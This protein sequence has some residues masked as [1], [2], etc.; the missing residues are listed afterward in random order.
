MLVSIKINNIALIS[1]SKIEMK[2]GFNVLTGETGAGK[3]IIID[4]LNFVLG[5]RADKSLIK[6]GEDS[7]RVEAVFDVPNDPEIMDFF[8]NNGLD[9][10]NTIIISRMMSIAGKNE[11]RVN[12]DIVT[13][14]MLRKL[15]SYLVDI[16]GQHEHQDLLDVK[17]HIV[18][19]DNFDN[20]VQKIKTKL[21]NILDNLQNINVQIKNLGG[22]QEDRLKSIELLQHEIEEIEQADIKEDEEE[23]LKVEKNRLNNFEKIYESLSQSISL[24]DGEYG[25]VS[26]SNVACKEL[27]NATRF[28]DSLNDLLQRLENIKYDSRDILDSLKEYLSNIDFSANRLE[29]IEQR[30]DLIKDIYRKFG[31]TYDSTISY[32][33]QA[34]LKL[35]D[36]ENCQDKI[37]KLQKEKSEILDELYDACRELTS[38]RRV[39]AQV[40][41]SAILIEL[42]TL[43][44]KNSSF[45]VQNKANYTRENIEQF[46]TTNGA[47]DIEFLFSANLGE[48]A[49]PLS[50]IISGGEMS[51]F[52]LAIKC[53]AI[54]E[55]DYKTL[56]FDEIDS[57]IG[58]AIGAV[59]GQKM[60]QISKNYQV[61]CITHLAQIA[62]I[63]DTHFKITKYS[64][65]EKTYTKVEILD[66]EERV[67]EL[68][69]MLSGS[70]S[71][72][73]ILH[74][75]ELLDSAEKYKNNR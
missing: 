55:N 61:I 59:L 20:S 53:V 51:R 35:Y 45:V 73:A 71:S 49:K 66:R 69:R 13:I 56:I 34:K 38:K 68:A 75:K 67:A 31:G 41:E 36:L 70:N 21:K 11:C 23:T 28:D 3:S 72:V 24:L 14:S 58:G 43:G 54:A 8:E 19:L 60:S 27:E 63:A 46:A 16:H 47:D 15:T 42:A 57:G 32:L 18:F 62:C 29:E 1:S 50:K 52:M 40:F 39:I 48:P 26:N 9:F 65:E 64:D 12:G 33:E 6:S 7:A 17:N 30:L 37:N 74:A 5:D 2:N 22:S 4:A 44:M 25:I 10:D